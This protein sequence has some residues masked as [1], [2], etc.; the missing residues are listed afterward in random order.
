MLSM[1]HCCE[2]LFRKSAFAI[3]IVAA[4]GIFAAE[5]G[6]WHQPS[7]IT[8]SDCHIM[9]YSE[10]GMRP[11]DAESGGPFPRLL[12]ASTTNNLC[13]TCHDGTD[14]DAPDVIGSLTYETAAGYFANSGGVASD[15]AHNLGM[16][17]E[18]VPPGSPVSADGL[19]LS[20]A[21]CH[22]PHGSSNYRNLLLNPA[23]SDN[24]SDVDVIVS[25]T[26]TADGPAPGGY[27]PAQVYIPTNVIYK[28]GMSDWCNDCH[29]NFH[30]DTETGYPEPWFRHPQDATING[31]DYADYTH[32]W[33]GTI[34][35]RIE[36]ESPDDSLVPSIDDQVFCLSCHKAH[37]SDRKSNLIYADDSRMLSTCQQC[38]NQ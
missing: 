10:D 24:S 28:S 20:C 9:H 37:G 3:I 14:T 30:G 16:A 23:G 2:T 7:Q 12:L 18:E 26:K 34:S 31:S 1:P 29:P 17:S 13:L 21:S 19:I 27:T 4:W 22:N 38:H 32:W 35:N 8:C 15:N 25:Q 11:I 6:D 33:N 5:A 36:V